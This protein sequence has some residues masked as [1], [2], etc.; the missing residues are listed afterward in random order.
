MTP[1]QLLLLLRE[2]AN[3][4]SKSR[5][6]PENLVQTHTLAS[7]SLTHLKISYLTSSLFEVRGK[8]IVALKLVVVQSLLRESL[9]KFP[10]ECYL[11]C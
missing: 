4:A 11:P 9:S 6:R 3:P 5:C 8:G 2:S 1:A 10:Y 7:P